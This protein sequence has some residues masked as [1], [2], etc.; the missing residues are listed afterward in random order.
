MLVA[1]RVRKHLCLF[2]I[3]CS[4]S[5]IS[6]NKSVEQT[7]TEFQQTE[8]VDPCCNVWVPKPFICGGVQ[9]AR[10]TQY[11]WL[12]NLCNRPSMAV[13]LVAYPVKADIRARSWISI[14]II[15]DRHYFDWH[16]MLG[17]PVAMIS[18]VLTSS[19]VD[20]YSRQRNWLIVFQVLC[21][22]YQKIFSIS[23]GCTI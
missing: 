13:D 19:S 2:C 21:F 16:E 15:M 20:I 7:I 1:W 14:Y 11:T 8:N 23:L 18:Y 3:Y 4:T 10:S 9:T 5:M 17:I 22:M 6:P 12:Y